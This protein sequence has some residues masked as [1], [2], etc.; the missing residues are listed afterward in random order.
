MSRR[1]YILGAGCLGKLVAHAIAGIPN[2]P[3]VTLLVRS[4]AMLRFWGKSDQSIEVVTGGVAE[5]RFGYDVEL[6]PH[7]KAEPP[8]ILEEESNEDSSSSPGNAGSNNNHAADSAIIHHVIISVKAPHTILALSMIAHRLTRD[9]TILFL[10]N[11]VGMVDEVNEQIFP[12]ETTRPNYI[13][14]VITHGVYPSP[15]NSFSV[16][17]AGMGTTALGVIPRKSMLQP[18][19]VTDAISQVAPSARYLMR[20]LTSIPALTATGFA[21]T[22]LL[23]LQLEKLAM[24]CII[25]PLTVMF[26][27]RNGELLQNLNITRVFRLL[28]AEISLVIRSLPELQGVPNVTMRFSPE[29]LELMVSTLSNKTS[30][31]YSSMLQ[32]VRAGKI[33]EIDYLNGYIVRRGEEM[34]LKCVMNYMLLHMVK[35]K[36][37]LQRTRDNDLLPFKRGS[38]E[39]DRRHQVPKD[40]SDADHPLPSSNG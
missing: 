5:K 8:H 22:D 35:G 12:D 40:H 32:D 17:H 20:I 37:F 29:R 31:N 33:T 14:G 19:E 34:G 38:S 39:R 36:G 2:R 15:W 18:M 13:V 25:N 27:C 4:I 28:L 9:S 21:P 3:P 1:I 30:Q 16:V 7:S 24:N 26:D 6:L 10:Q 23:Q 11:G